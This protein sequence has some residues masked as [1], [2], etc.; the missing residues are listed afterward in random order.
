MLEFLQEKD[1]DTL[2]TSGAIVICALI[3]QQE[4][5]LILVLNTLLQKMPVLH[6]TSYF[7][8]KAVKSS[9]I[10][11]TF[12]AEFPVPYAEVKTTKEVIK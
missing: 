1:I 4:Q 11:T 8:E 5:H 10:H 3:Q 12:M 9:E 7:Q 2:T 6:E